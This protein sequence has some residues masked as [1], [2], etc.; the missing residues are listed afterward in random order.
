MGLMDYFPKRDDEREKPVVIARQ[1]VEP[2]IGGEGLDTGLADVAALGYKEGRELPMEVVPAKVE[3]VKE[4]EKAVKPEGLPEEDYRAA[5]SV[6]SPERIH[7]L[8]AGFDAKSAEPFY[9]QLY[10]TIRRQPEEL[11]EKKL[12]AMRSMAG[13]G[14]AL[15]LLAQTVAASQG[16]LID[17]RHADESASARTALNID[18]LK[19][20]YRK[21]RDAYDAG[22]FGARMK[23][24]EGARGAY[25]KDR[26]ALLAY[27]AKLKKDKLED[28]F[29]NKRFEGEMVYRYEGLKE[30]ARQNE[31]A[32]RLK[33]EK[34]DWDRQKG[35]VT[36][37][38]TPKG[39]MD[40]Y[41][42]T[43]GMTYRVPEKKWKANYTQIFNRIK[44][45][46]FR[47]YPRL[48]VADK[49]GSL[50][51]SEKEEYIKQ[52]MYDNPLALNFL[53][54]IA[55]VK[56][57]D[58]EPEMKSDVPELPDEELEELKRIV[59]KEKEEEKAL[60]EI[61]LYLKGRGYN[62]S[63]IERVIRTIKQ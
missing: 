20:S 54:N 27:L 33:R 57:R 32:N 25:M 38:E 39:Y 18:R 30:K 37:K 29:R 45:D 61:G 1:G 31:I 26:A 50:K 62:R 28:A 53:D 5:L 15:G 7:E 34:L 42:P 47:Q 55:E 17:V 48:K 41:D 8:Y 24:V 60:R 23:D 12:Q 58:G 36:K 11:N 43:S 14:D 21:D 63:E 13:L 56:F 44:E 4:R 19:A 2:V 52:Y 51:P 49:M 9:E 40:F 35:Q 6:F 46:L 10:R 22:L 16:G 59:G 3:P